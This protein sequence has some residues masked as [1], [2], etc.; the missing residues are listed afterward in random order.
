M[1]LPVHVFPDGELFLS[2]SDHAALTSR[3]RFNAR[4]VRLG[5]THPDIMG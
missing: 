4:D 5:I 1:R 3:N 2:A